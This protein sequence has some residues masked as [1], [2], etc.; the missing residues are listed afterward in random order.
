M[1]HSLSIL[2]AEAIMTRTG[3]NPS[4][5]KGGVHLVFEQGGDATANGV[6][7]R[8]CH[9]ARSCNPIGSNLLTAPARRHHHDMIAEQNGF[10][11]MC[12]MRIA[13]RRSALNTARS[14]CWITVRVCASRAAN[15]SSISNIFGSLTR[16]ETVPPAGA[17][18]RKVPAGSLLKA[19]KPDRGDL[20]AH[21]LGPLRL[22]TRRSRKPNRCLVAPASQ[23][24]SASLEDNPPVRAGSE[25]RHQAAPRRCL[26]SRKLATMLRKVV[27][28]QPLGPRM[29]KNLSTPILTRSMPSR[30]MSSSSHESHELLAQPAHLQIR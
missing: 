24:N 30:A 29:V 26:P 23:G 4:S 28:P 25:A 20:A 2:P 8:R 17:C 9:I 22:L 12:V 19:G 10:F 3:C 1:V 16:S 27:L 5:G 21:A 7:F 11:D 15:G 18:R 6:E 14:S 13:V